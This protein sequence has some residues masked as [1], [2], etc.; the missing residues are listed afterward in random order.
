VS[1]LRIVELIDGD[2]AEPAEE[3]TG[4]L[5]DPNTGTPLRRQRQT[6]LDRLDV[7]LSVADQA[8]YRDDWMGR[9]AADRA[10]LLLA[11]GEELATRGEDL[12][13]ADSTDSGVPLSSTRLL[14]AAGADALRAAA[15]L[16]AS[17]HERTALAGRAGP[18][19]QWRLPWGPAAV[20]V[21][22]N[23]PAPTALFKTAAA[24]AAGCPV[25]LKPS[26][27]A[28]HFAAPLAE[29]AVESGLPTAMLQIVQGGA[30][31]GQAL[32]GDAR[33]Q[34]LSYT[35]GVA[36][37][38]A[39]A[40][41]CAPRLIPLDL[42]LSGNNPVVILPDADLDEAAT[43]LV[44]G[45]LLLNG[46]WC[47]G[48]RRAVVPEALADR[49]V[50]AVLARLD[51]VVIG[52]TTEAGT[53]VGPMAHSQHLERLQQQL[54]E[55][56]ASGHTVRSVG[57]TP[58]GAGHFLAPVLITGDKTR[59]LRDEIFGPVLV[60]QRYSDV[61]EAV[62]I[63][64]DHSFGLSGYVFGGD[65]AQAAGVGRRLRAGQVSLN[66]IELL[67]IAEQGVGSMW[68]LSGLGSLGGPDRVRF[69]TGARVV[70]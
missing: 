2:C 38:R 1:E 28:P 19:E 25:V 52:P 37:G 31:V 18:A 32:V 54:A 69:F 66:R 64:N 47:A 7:A 8:H 6:S 13:A 68:G 12:A 43:Q 60:V 21:P 55:C 29:A 53:H 26:E 27:W 9:P 34:A 45:M 46:Q 24:L 41:A 57:T 58:A 63:A 44:G 20:V 51:G 15:G 48:P 39:V 56:S 62:V 16:V 5:T 10:A 40:A 65:L 50:A 3:L 35:G 49:L 17:G 61:E 36:G 11:F 59:E 33:V 23:A 70:G 42:E 22:W 14:A 67:P 30:A 4:W